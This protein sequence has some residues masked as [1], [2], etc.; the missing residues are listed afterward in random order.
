MTTA[1]MATTGCGVTPGD[2]SGGL[3][4]LAKIDGSREGMATPPN[5]FA[6]LEVAYDAQTAQQMW[7]QNVPGDL[8][9][10]SGDPRD[11]GRYGNLADVDFGKQAVAL[12]SSGESGSCPGWVSGVSIDGG[13]VVVT[14]DTDSGFSG[15]C[16][17]D[18]NPYR[19]L[20]A[21][22]RADLPEPDAVAT[23]KIRIAD[24]DIGSPILLTAYPLS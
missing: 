10:Q 8:P 18:Y 16:S 20:V 6:V 17:S 3:S 1:L 15:A 5:T 2:G 22:D 23:T 19:V 24:T 12:W 21:V 9:E 7:N 4:T 14:E 13:Y 11:P